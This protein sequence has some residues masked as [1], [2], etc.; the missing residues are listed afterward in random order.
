MGVKNAK[1]FALWLPKT[2]KYG[3]NIHYKP[4]TADATPYVRVYTEYLAY[5]Y[6]FLGPD[7]DLGPISQALKNKK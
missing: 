7:K 5:T 6:G 3:L 1:K 2:H 4:I